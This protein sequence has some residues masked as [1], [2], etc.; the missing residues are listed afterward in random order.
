MPQ[1]C[2]KLYLLQVFVSATLYLFY[3]VQTVTLFD[4]L[5]FGGHLVLTFTH[6]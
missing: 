4:Q 5:F 2:L 6:P 1:F 3:C